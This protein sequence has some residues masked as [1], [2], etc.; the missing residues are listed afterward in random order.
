LVSSVYEEYKKY[1]EKNNK[2]LVSCLAIRK[3]EGISSR[4][5]TVTNKHDIDA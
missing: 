3:E 2:V 5:S 1:C 4:K